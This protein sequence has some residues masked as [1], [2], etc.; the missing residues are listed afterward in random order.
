MVVAN[1][2]L[3]ILA[4]GSHFDRIGSIDG[5]EAA[6][7]GENLETP[8]TAIGMTDNHAAF[9]VQTCPFDFASAGKGLRISQSASNALG[10]GS[11]LAGRL[12]RAGSECQQCEDTQ[13][14]PLPGEVA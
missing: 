8:E 3:G 11:S 10:I 4:V 6:A 14:P 7:V 5:R 1:G 12:T 13:N 9:T 2:D